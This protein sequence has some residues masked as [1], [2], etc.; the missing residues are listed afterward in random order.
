VL[1]VDQAI[2]QRVIDAALGLPIAHENIDYTPISGTP[3]AEL[4]VFQND[5][6]AFS[7]TS[8]AQSDGFFQVLFH[9]P[10]NTSA[11]QA[12]TK[13]DQLMA[14]FKIGQKI[15]R[16]GVTLVVNRVTRLEPST[17][18]GWYRLPVR[19]FFRSFLTR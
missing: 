6:T 16:D 8:S 4:K 19:I 2:T 11:I 18:G 5:L 1:V 3:Y 15:T 12:K 17:D 7:V 10:Q 14:S 9:Y 13:A